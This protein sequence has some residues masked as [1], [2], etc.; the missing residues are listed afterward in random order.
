[1]QRP[2]VPIV[3]WLVW[4]L[5]AVAGG[6]LFDV[7]RLPVAWL[8]GPM[9]TAMILSMLLAP[10]P[11]IERNGSTVGQWIIGTMMGA[12]FSLT[13]LRAGLPHIPV[14]LGLIVFTAG[15]CLLNGW[16]L[17]RLAGVDATTGFLGSLPGA[18]A[19]SV[20]LAAD[21]KADQFMVVMLMYIRVLLIILLVPVI[22]SPWVDTET[23]AGGG[24]GGRVFVSPAPWFSV[25]SLALAVGVAWLGRRARIPSANYLGPFV[26]FLFLK[27]LL[28]E[29]RLG[30]PSPCFRLGMLLLGV[31]VG[32][33]F[34][35][36][37][38]RQLWRPALIQVGLVCGLLLAC[39][40]AG[41]VF[42]RATGVD[43]LTAVLCTTPGGKESMTALSIE[44]GGNVEL[45]IVMQTVRWLL[46]MFLGPALALWMAGRVG[47]TKIAQAEAISA[48]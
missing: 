17:Q 9:V 25:L 36:N 16:L 19:A 5:V 37:R 33:R 18:A 40:G 28:P 48:D 10:P 6:W 15:L 29:L 24:R 13:A 35:L 8:L 14:L 11:G 27:N 1:M 22:L 39:L 44:I 26:L 47:G 32:A 12:S 45:V 30:L 34:D 21:L 3:R 42:H 38:F 4:G 31:A 43:L 2:L 7:L 23:V 41:Y 20:A 46:V